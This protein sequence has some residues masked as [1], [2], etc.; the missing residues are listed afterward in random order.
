MSLR[1]FLIIMAVGTVTAWAAVGLIITAVDPAETQAGVFAAFYASL[2]LALTGTLSLGG[3]G[4]RRLLF[5][6][7]VLAV[8]QVALSFR[9]AILLSG[10]VTA[11]M[12]LQARGLLNWLNAGLLIATLTLLEFFFISARQKRA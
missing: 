5:R 6:N 2:F 1:Q 12:Y 9:Q 10:L 7:R 3:F 8:R 4:V 11:A